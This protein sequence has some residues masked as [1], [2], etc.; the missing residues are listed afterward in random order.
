M[1]TILI[2]S[3][4]L[5]SLLM[6]VP[7]SADG[8]EHKKYGHKEKESCAFHCG[9]VQCD[10][11]SNTA[12]VCKAATTE[13][14]SCFWHTTGV[15]TNNLKAGED[16]DKNADKEKANAAALRAKNEK[17]MADEK[18]AAKKAE[19]DKKAADKAAKD[20]ADKE[21]ADKAAKDKAAKDKADKE[22]KK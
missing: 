3:A 6:T 11:T 14:S 21:K 18:A 16:L 22:K 4:A 19:D 9:E 8:V 10:D 1:K 13:K 12:W 5:V 17:T 20:K 7:A 15:C 2:A